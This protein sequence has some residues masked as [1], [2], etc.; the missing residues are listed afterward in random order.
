MAAGV[1]KGLFAQVLRNS[2]CRPCR[3]PAC[4]AIMCLESLLR[5]RQEAELRPQITQYLSG[6]VRPPAATT[7]IIHLVP[8]KTFFQ[9]KLHFREALGELKTFS[10]DKCKTEHRNPCLRPACVAIMC[11]ESL[12]RQ[13]Q[14]SELRPRITQYLSGRVRPPA[15]TTFISDN[16]ATPILDY[17]A[18]CQ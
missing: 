5:Q 11:L 9:N 16:L 14:E 8:P 12:L 3:R 7:L 1:G 4:V 17:L 6:R 2:L 13:R 18:G 10:W 15:A